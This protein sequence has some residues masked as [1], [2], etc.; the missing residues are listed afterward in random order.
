MAW[1]C[2]YDEHTN[3]NR[4][5]CNVCSSRVATWQALDRHLRSKHSIPK[6]SIDGTYLAV[7]SMNKYRGDLTTYEYEHAS[8]HPEDIDRF[9]CKLCNGD[10]L[11]SSAL[12]HYEDKHK[13]SKADLKH[14]LV[15]K[16]GNALR[17]RT[18]ARPF[19]ESYADYEWLTAHAADDLAAEAADNV[20]EAEAPE[21][22]AMDQEVA[23]AIYTTADA[24]GNG[25]GGQMDTMSDVAHITT[26]SV[27]YKHDECQL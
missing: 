19:R 3:P 10:F 26:M 22:D 9:I 6:A 21:D 16:D 7:Q 15:I 23:G 2:T 12:R 4:L 5:Y 27:K 8:P 25:F 13:I 1:A 17:N 11:S 20:E 24:H 18:R 14:W